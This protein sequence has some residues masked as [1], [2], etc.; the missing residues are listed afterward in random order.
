MRP[1]PVPA[2]PVPSGAAAAPPAPHAAGGFRFIEREDLGGRSRQLL[3]LGVLALHAGIVW[4]LLQAKGEALEAAPEPK[5]LTVQWIAPPAPTPKPPAPPPPRVQKLPPQ[6]PRPVLVAPPTPS[7]EAPTFTAP[8]PPAEPAP[9]AVAAVAAPPSP[10]PAPAPA[11][12]AAPK[13]LPSS[14]VQY[15]VPLQLSFP[16]ASK[17]LGESG[18][19]LL[20]V[21]V[22][23]QGVPR[24]VSV[25]QSSGYARLDE[26]AVRAM[27][28]A[29]FKPYM[30][31]GQAIEWTTL[32]PIEFNL[33]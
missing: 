8:P 10:A 32:A 29:R 18:T 22:T 1:L 26:A 12:P 21:V 17:R 25:K 28:S 14:A 31:Q 15:L 20:R 2:L 11:P 19:V 6:P 16:A 27:R 4:A 13:L 33:E 9:V 7:A 23:A 5:V 3:S 24:E 30:D